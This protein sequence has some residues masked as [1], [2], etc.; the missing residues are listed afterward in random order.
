MRGSSSP[1]PSVTAQVISG[2]LPSVHGSR[3]WRGTGEEEE[4]QMIATGTEQNSTSSERSEGSG[5]SSASSS[6]QTTPHERALLAGRRI[7][8]PLHAFE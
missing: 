8:P 3:G 4:K 5:G 1:R 2:G 7:N 6:G